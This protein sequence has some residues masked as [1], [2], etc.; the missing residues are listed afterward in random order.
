MPDVEPKSLEKFRRWRF[1]PHMARTERVIVSQADGPQSQRELPQP[2]P[3][4]ARRVAPTIKTV[5]HDW[6]TGCR[7][8]YANLVRPAGQRSRLDEGE[9]PQ[10]GIIA[11]LQNTKAGF[12]LP[13]PARVHF[14]FAVRSVRLREF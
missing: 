3:G 9:L 2:S 7:K 8:V 4:Q 11:C 12:R 10:R 1:N 13:A 6:M 14:H 5:A